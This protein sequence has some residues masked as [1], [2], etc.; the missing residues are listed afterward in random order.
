LRREVDVSPSHPQQLRLPDASHGRDEDDDAKRRA[1]C[2]AVHRCVGDCLD[3]GVQLLE[4]QELQVGTG[5]AH[6][7]APSPRS[8]LD[9][10]GRRPAF[11]HGQREDRIQ[12]RHGVADRLWR[13]VLSEHHPGEALDVLGRHR[14]DSSPASTGA[15]WIRCIDSQFWR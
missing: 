10:V 2:V 1:E 6:P 11:R 12:E 8:T 4:R 15:M 13:G 5:I 9:R 3:H 14:V 7:A